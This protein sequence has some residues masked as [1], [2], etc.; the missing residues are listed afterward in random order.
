GGVYFVPAFTGLG[1]PHWDP[2]ARGAIIG[3]T[4]DSG[5]AHIVRA[6]LE[7][8]AYQTAD[9]I[10]AL[11]QDGIAEPGALRVD[12]GMAANG[13][14]LQFLADVTGITVERPSCSETTAAGAAFLAG[15]GAGLFASM[16][17]VKAAWSLDFRAVSKT[18]PGH[19]EELL[20]GWR[21][22]IARAAS[23]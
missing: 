23:R 22:A 1:A 21:K 3:L 18:T 16:D 20:A 5:T 10:S 13:W 11:R 15:L 4:R 19:R 2:D 12:G 17:D 6:G 8:V 7:S 9:L 14:F